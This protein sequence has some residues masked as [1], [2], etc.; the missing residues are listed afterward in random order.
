MQHRRDLAESCSVATP[1]RP[2]IP[3]ATYSIDKRCVGQT[4]RLVP[5]KQVVKIVEYCLAKVASDTGVELHA[6]TFMSNHFH[7]VLTDVRGVL[8]TFMQS[9]DNLIS[10]NLN[11]LRGLSG[12][13]FERGYNSTPL[14]DIDSAIGKAAY[15]LA[16][17]TAAHLVSRARGWKGVTSARMQFGQA[18]RVSRPRFGIWG[19]APRE[20]A[21]N[22]KRKRK[23]ERAR[24]RERRSGQFTS[25]EEAELSLTPFPQSL[26]SRD[27]DSVMEEIRE[28]VQKREH[29]AEQ[30]RIRANISVVGMSRVARRAWWDF[31][32]RSED[33]FTH[34]ERVAGRDQSKVA[35]AKHRNREFECEYANALDK[36]RK[37]ERPVFPA[38][39]WLMVRR[40]GYA[41]A[42]P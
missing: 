12:S 20:G 27:S 32:G 15:A 41:C 25:P 28:E 13:N 22:Q 30:V 40:Y 2:V 14:L 3:G 21:K 10:R 31:P 6:F 17:P 5:T 35:I 11:A 37:G 29:A 38:G 19:E 23:R 1:P 33:M 16:N 18:R 7:L 34:V 8:P 39:T 4:F 9:L 36:V 26:T 24:G 42:S